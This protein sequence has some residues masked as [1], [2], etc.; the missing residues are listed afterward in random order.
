MLQLLLRA[1]TSQSIWKWQWRV[2]FGVVLAEMEGIGIHWWW[3]NCSVKWCFQLQEFSFFV[4]L[5]CSKLVCRVGF[6][7]HFDGKNCIVM[8]I[9]NSMGYLG[10]GIKT[11]WVGLGRNLSSHILVPNLRH[12]LVLAPVSVPTFKVGTEPFHP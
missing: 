7:C 3:R 2:R 1:R 5:L 6:G 4:C 8:I 11:N 12:R 10:I 9:V